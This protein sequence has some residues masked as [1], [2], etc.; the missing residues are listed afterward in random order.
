[1]PDVMLGLFPRSGENAR[2]RPS[3]SPTNTP[4]A[5]RGKKRNDRAMNHH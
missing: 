5:L 1:M 2:E 4:C 3:S